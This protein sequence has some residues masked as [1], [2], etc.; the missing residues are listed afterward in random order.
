MWLPWGRGWSPKPRV[1]AVEAWLVPWATCGC[2]G[3]VADPVGF[4][5]CR[6]GVAGPL[7]FVW[8]PWGR[9]Q[10]P[11]LCVAAVAAWQ[12]PWA[13]CGRCGDVAVS[14]ALVA[15]VGAWLVPWAPGGRSGNISFPWAPCGRLGGV[16]SPLAFVGP[17]RGRG[18]FFGL[19]VAGM[20]AWPVTWALCGFRR[21]VA[22]P[23]SPV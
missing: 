13:A 14:L 18:H 11:G 23:L 21:R 22:G 16:A 20:K 1:A 12:V 15:A 4:C 6:G 17:Q 19:R 5:G 7:G 10:S 2:R 8:P 3:G 9:G